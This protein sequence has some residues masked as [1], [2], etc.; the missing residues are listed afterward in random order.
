MA[1]LVGL[2]NWCEA[3]GVDFTDKA[4]RLN[5]IVES[6]LRQ[7]PD[8]LVALDTSGPGQFWTEYRRSM[9]LGADGL[10]FSTKNISYSPLPLAARP[11]LCTL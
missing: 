2:S 11:E 7:H 10:A 5:A 8:V 3:S 9:K 6:Q 4:R 1:N